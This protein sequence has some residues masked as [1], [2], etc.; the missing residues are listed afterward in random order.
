MRQAGGSGEDGWALRPVTPVDAAALLRLAHMPEVYR[1]LFDGVPP[2]EAAIRAWIDTSLEAMAAHGI[3]AWVLAGPDVDCAGAVWLRPEADGRTAEVS[4]ML[5]PRW[6]GRGLATR[7]AWTAV[8]RAFD[9]GGMDLVFAGADGPNARSFA[10]M[11]RLG[12]AFRGDVTYPLGPGMEYALRREDPGPD[13]AP[14]LLAI[15]R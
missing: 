8:R 10:V 14:S 7:M 11:R 6:W 12:M 15:A 1:Y 13:P 9:V 2:E 3:G 4:Y 5:D